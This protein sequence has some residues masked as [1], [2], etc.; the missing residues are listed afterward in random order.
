MSK[1]TVYTRLTI[2]TA[3]VLSNL[4]RADL[5]VYLPNARQA[6]LVLYRGSGRGLA[7]PD[8]NRLR[9]HGLATVYANR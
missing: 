9:T 2:E 7:D 4:G 6:D 3:Q 5:A 8:Y 1:E